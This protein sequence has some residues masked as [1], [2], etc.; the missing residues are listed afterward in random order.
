M[1]LATVVFHIY[2]KIYWWESYESECLHVI[3]LYSSTIILNTQV[4]FE[5]RIVL[6]PKCNKLL[7]REF[8]L[9][10]F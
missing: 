5:R 1:L 9:P 4:I 3:I 2:M 7:W 10:K 8:S 6:S